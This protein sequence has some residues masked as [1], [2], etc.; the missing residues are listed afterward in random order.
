MDSMPVRLLAVVIAMMLTMGFVVLQDKS[1]KPK[2]VVIARATPTVL[3][4]LGPGRCQQ[5]P[6]R[7]ETP[8]WYP[9]DL[10]LP[11]GSYPAAIKLPATSNYPR[12]IFAVRGTLRD[13]IIY[14]L[15][16][17][18]RSGWALG[19]GEAEAGE[20]EDNFYRP[21]SDVRGAFIARSDYCD[22]GWTWVYIVLGSGQQGAPRP[23]PRPTGS[24]S[25]LR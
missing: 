6:A 8:S 2:A 15:S 4:T 9:D 19:R 7:A 18:P 10:P 14:A 16:V 13:F 3:G 20:A 21:G 12:A 1:S 5:L 11:P 22:A 25:P 24:A 23:T 17:W